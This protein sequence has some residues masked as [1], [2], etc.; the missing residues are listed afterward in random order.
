M[1]VLLRGADLGIWVDAVAAARA[2]RSETCLPSYSTLIPAYSS[3]RGNYWRLDVHQALCG[4]ARQ[5]GPGAV[6]SLAD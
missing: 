4:A 5:T 6:Q 2:N 1:H 3:S